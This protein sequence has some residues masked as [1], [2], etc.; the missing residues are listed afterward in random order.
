[1]WFGL[2]GLVSRGVSESDPRAVRRS[3]IGRGGSVIAT[4]P[5]VSVAGLM[6][7]VTR[8]MRRKNCKVGARCRWNAPSLPDVELGAQ[9]FKAARP[10]CCGVVA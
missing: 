3:T 2:V 7:V 6:R 8:L 1:M 9:Q 4:A 5:E 10:F